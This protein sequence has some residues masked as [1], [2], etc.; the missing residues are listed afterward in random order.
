[1]WP[2]GVLADL[3]SGDAHRI[4]LGASAVTRQWDRNDLLWLAG[5]AAAIRQATNGIDLGGALRPNA[6][7]LDL[8]MQRLAMAMGDGCF[9]ALYMKDFFADPKREAAELRVKVISQKDDPKT[10]QTHWQ[11]SC[12]TCRQGYAVTQDDSWHFP[13]FAWVAH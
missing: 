8:A 1:M 6:V 7:I 10:W 11:L 4:W 13:H 3:L 9:C 12:C 2:E 5:H